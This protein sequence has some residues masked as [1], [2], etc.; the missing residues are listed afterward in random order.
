MDVSLAGRFIS[1]N[2][3][4]TLKLTYSVLYV[5]PGRRA[6]GHDQQV[7]RRTT[8][9]SHRFGHLDR[10]ERHRAKAVAAGQRGGESHQGYGEK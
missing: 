5:R 9:E 4:V 1:I 10:E 8:A 7:L 6:M 2:E 3:K